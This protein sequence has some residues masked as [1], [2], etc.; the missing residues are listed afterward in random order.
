MRKFFIKSIIFVFGLAGFFLL[1]NITV[2]TGFYPD[3]NYFRIKSAP[4]FD[5]LELLFAGSSYTYSGINP[6]YFDKQNIKIFN[7]GI[8]TASTHFIEVVLDDYLD[9]VSNKP[10][11]IVIEITPMSFSE[12]MDSW[13]SLPVNRY[14]TK[15]FSDEKA[16][17]RHLDLLVYIKL[18]REETN[19]KL[20]HLFGREN[21][22]PS[23]NERIADIVIKNKGFSNSEDIFEE[24]MLTEH[25]Q[26]YEDLLDN[27]FDLNRLEHLKK[28]IAKLNRK[29][30]RV[31]ILEFPT[32]KLKHF[33][34]YEYLENYE[35]VFIE[36]EE[37][38]ID[39]IRFDKNIPDKCFRNIDHMNS[40]GAKIFSQWAIEK[41]ALKGYLHVVQ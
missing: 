13:V 33:L 40:E 3:S 24:K 16:L 30:I 22:A 36:L 21:H 19:K 39:F 15:P 10:Q 34:K 26:Y 11:T 23:G 12:K 28:L 37:N 5:A 32:F 7:L 29:G 35:R 31:V 1:I 25:R 38:G 4:K 27:N 8:A 6:E 9:A 14:L 2:N 17:I 41:L 20:L 18:K